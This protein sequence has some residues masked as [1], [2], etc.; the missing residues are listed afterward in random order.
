MPRTPVLPETNSAETSAAGRSL[1]LPGAPGTDVVSQDGHTSST[2]SGSVLDEL[3]RRASSTGRHGNRD[4]YLVRGLWTTDLL[5]QPS[6]VERLFA[7]TFVLAQTTTL[8]CS[9]VAEPGPVPRDL[10]GMDAR[11]CAGAPRALQ[12]AILDS[13][14]AKTVSQPARRLNLQGGAASKAVDR[15]N[16]VLEE[17]DHVLGYPTAHERERISLVNVGAVG[18][19]LKVLQ[20]AGYQVRATDLDPSLVGERLAG[21]RVES[22]LRSPQ[23]VA[24]SRVAIV[25]GMTLVTNTLDDILQSAAAAGT[26]VV[27]FAETGAHFCEE[28][29]RLGV[30]SAISE[31]FPFYIFDGTTRVEV[32]RRETGNVA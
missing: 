3:W 7:Y 31:P 32:F 25:T 13:L 23:I 27:I 26:R 12:V 30:D 2:S 10:I 16:L 9:Y 17:V 14:Y 22:G 29:C 28:Y 24:E 1:D 15:A 11:D 19:F 4:E 18:H 20:T 8:G 5:F 6:P 21:V